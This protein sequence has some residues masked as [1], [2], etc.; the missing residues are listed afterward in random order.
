MIWH[1]V[2]FGTVGIMLRSSD[3]VL[4]LTDCQKRLRLDYDSSVKLGVPL[5]ESRNRGAKG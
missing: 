2:A 3:S 5:E 1:Y 4:G